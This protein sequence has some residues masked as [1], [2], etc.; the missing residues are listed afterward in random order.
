MKLKVWGKNV[1]L[2]YLAYFGLMLSCVLISVILLA[3]LFAV[4]IG[5]L[6]N[7]LLYVVSNNFDTCYSG[8][9]IIFTCAMYGLVLES[10]VLFIIIALL[11]LLL[12]IIFIL[13]QLGHKIH[14][15]YRRKA[16]Q[17]IDPESTHDTDRRKSD[18]VS[19][20]EEFE[21]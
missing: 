19:S 21:V 3:I 4:P 5:M 14:Q 15:A 12:L 10:L 8:D 18:L 11:S 6:S 9:T 1:N 20:S 17:D 7:L 16:Y 13:I 2:K